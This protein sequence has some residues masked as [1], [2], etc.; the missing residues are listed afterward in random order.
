MIKKKIVVT[1][2]SIM[3][4]TMFGGCTKAE[5]EDVELKKNNTASEFS[6]GMVTDDGGLGDIAYNDGAITGLKQA[7]EELGVKIYS[8]E[9]KDTE[10]YE[11]NIME[12]TKANDLVFA[13][14]F[15]MKD[16]LETVAKDNS[17]KDFVIIDER[18]EMPNIK[19]ITFKEE[20]G[21]Y[22]MGVIAG[23]MTKTNK[24]GFIGGADMPIIQK[25][26]A[27]FAAGVKS[28]NEDAAEGLIN[29]KMVKYT[30]S[31]RDT[32]KGYDLAKGL[33][34]DGADV[35]FHASGAEGLGVFRVAKEMGRYAIGV[36]LDQGQLLEEYN[37]VILSSMIKK[38]DKAVFDTINEFI[39]GSFK[40][41][42]S[43]VLK[44]GL[45]EDGVGI[46]EST[47]NN[48][49]QDIIDLTNKYKGLIID[50][51]ITVPT[52]FDELNAFI[53]PKV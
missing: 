16:S 50:G 25:F 39:S 41:G 10:E 24:I 40:P 23:K 42:Q 30:S 7:N 5:E 28:V 20:E 29:E 6:V 1:I 44:L 14:G 27:G 2:L 21:A 38:V 37:G 51:T 22:L 17:E 32:G 19:S 12:I 45:K 15:R 52:T 31:F 26:E 35:I 18:S 49:P 47:K 48:V 11:K 3:M 46:A 34:E 4:I 9:T 13:V 43:N 8:V 36:D 33:Y 53:V